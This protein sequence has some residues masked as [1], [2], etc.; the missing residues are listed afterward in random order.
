MLGISFVPLLIATY[1]ILFVHASRTRSTLLTYVHRRRGLTSR[2]TQAMFVLILSSFALIT[3]YWAAWL[4]YV[5]IQVRLVLVDN[6]GMPLAQ[7]IVLVNQKTYALE[8]VDIVIAYL[9]VL[10][11]NFSAC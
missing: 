1:S 6:V 9:P 5:V 3:I 4:A 7:K 8:I 11:S 2:A 10:S